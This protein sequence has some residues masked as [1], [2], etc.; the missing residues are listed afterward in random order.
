MAWELLFL[1]LP[2]A[3]LS[4]WLIGRRGVGTRSTDD[5]FNRNADYLKGLNF[6]LNEQSD[7]AIEVFIRML[8]VDSETVETHFA[9]GNLFLRRGEVDRA[10]RIHQ[11]LIARPTLTPP[12]RQQALFELG[13]DYL[14]AGLLDRA[15]ALFQQVA[16]SAEFGPSALRQLLEV[17]Q[18]E[19]EWAS[20]IEVAHRLGRDGGAQE[21]APMVAHF[22]CEQ[23]DEALRRAESSAAARLLRQ[24]QAE[25]KHCVRAT[26]LEA[27]LEAARGDHRLAI[28]TLRRV[29]QQDASFLGETLEP[30]RDCFRQLAAEDELITLL[31]EMLVRHPYDANVALLLAEMLSE[32]EG[33]YKAGELLL[34]QI[35]RT[36]SLRG[37]SELI[38][39][40]LRRHEGMSAEELGTVGGLLRR[41]GDGKAAY[42]CRSCGFT[43]R[44]LHWQC[45]TCKAWNSVK[46]MQ[47]AESE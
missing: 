43:T 12:Q 37:V 21:L 40:R 47:G 45:P 44:T 18:L 19:K 23:A 9:L 13:R 10:I 6:I 42:R 15:E 17:Y 33:A 22:L 14:R 39:Y 5:C 27:K 28:R 11:N 34:R 29:E 32:R 7:K 26:L 4:G 24:A 8:E 3:A 20:A 31:N 35:V 30:L 25:D 46:P 16:S 2:V 41:I 1:L 36:P 38:E